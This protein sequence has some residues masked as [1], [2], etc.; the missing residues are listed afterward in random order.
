MQWIKPLLLLHQ[1]IIWSNE[2]KLLISLLVPNF[3]QNTVMFIHK[4]A[5]ENVGCKMAAILSQPQ[6]V[7][8]NAM[9]LLAL[10]LLS[11]THWSI[12]KMINTLQMALEH[13]FSQILFGLKFPYSLFVIVLLTIC[14]LIWSS[15]DW[16]ISLPLPEPMMTQLTDQYMHYQAQWV[17]YDIVTAYG[18]MGLVWFRWWL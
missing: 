10:G 15:G 7:N 3:N 1:A 11:F 4:N 18:I 17:N 9:L 8:I 6:R 5:F 14:P 13:A 2:G 16:T 12:N